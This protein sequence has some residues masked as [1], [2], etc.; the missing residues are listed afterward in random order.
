MNFQEFI[1]MGGF[2]FYVWSSYFITA[3]ILVGLFISIKMQRNRLI[4]QIRRNIRQQQ[5][6]NET[7]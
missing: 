1:D 4:K 7:N 2:G 6:D 3:L 5:K